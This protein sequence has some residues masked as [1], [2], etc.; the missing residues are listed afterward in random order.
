MHGNGL[1]KSYVLPVYHQTLPLE[2][3][4]RV[5]LVLTGEGSSSHEIKEAKISFG[6]ELTRNNHAT[7]DI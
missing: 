4:K 2:E 1:W 7:L 5:W 6:H 3:K